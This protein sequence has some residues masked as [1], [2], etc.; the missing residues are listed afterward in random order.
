MRPGAKSKRQYWPGCDAR[1]RPTL[2]RLR[3]VFHCHQQR[4]GDRVKKL[5]R[6]TK[7]YYWTLELFFSGLIIDAVPRRYL[8]DSFV[9]W[10]NRGLDNWTWNP[11]P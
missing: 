3:N 5:F 6:E 4:L 7:H 11:K 10:Y 8:P 1:R 2:G 9:H